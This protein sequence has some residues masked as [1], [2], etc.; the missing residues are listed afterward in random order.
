MRFRS[1]TGGSGNK[2][3]KRPESQYHARSDSDCDSTSIKESLSSEFSD[4]PEKMRLALDVAIGAEM[5]EQTGKAGDG[6]ASWQYNGSAS[7]INII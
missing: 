7:R 5:A 2:S 1:E 4:L 6:M 3:I